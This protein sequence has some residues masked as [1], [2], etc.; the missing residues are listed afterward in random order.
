LITDLASYGDQK[1]SVAL[2]YA[3]EHIR[4][5]V[6]PKWLCGVRAVSVW[7]VSEPSEPKQHK[8]EG[9]GN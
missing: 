9:H 4:A 1:F 2:H 7:I 6:W 5:L 8:N 3:Q